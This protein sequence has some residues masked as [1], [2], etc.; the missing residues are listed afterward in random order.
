MNDVPRIGISVFVD[1]LPKKGHEPTMVLKKKNT[2]K[3]FWP[4]KNNEL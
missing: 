2:S 3:P 4:P 1:Y